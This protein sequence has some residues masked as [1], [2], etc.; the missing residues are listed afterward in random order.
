MKINAKDVK[1]PADVPK[2]MEKFYVQHYLEATQGSGRLMLFAGDQKMEHLNDDFVGLT[3]EGMRIPEDDSDP[4]H[5]FRIASKGT[6][7]VF[8]TQLGMIAR[9]GRDY[10][11]IPYLVKVNSK[12]DLVGTDQ[13]EPVSLALVDFEDILIMKEQSGLNVVGIGYTVFLGSELEAEML[14]EAG[15][16]VTW[17]HQNGMIAVLWM[18]PRGKAVKNDKDPHLIAGAAG[19][20]LCLGA[21]FAKVNYPKVDGD[22]KKRAQA[23]KEAVKA[24]GRTKIITSGGNARDVK[25]FLQETYDQIHISGCMGNATGRNI[26]QKA[27][28]EAVRM[29]DA[30][31]AITIGDKDVDFAYSVYKG[32][33]KFKV[34]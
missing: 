30:I 22:E 5:F 33:K 24:A 7:G 2:K 9:Y 20:A 18:Y 3:K 26:H 10:P 19:V 31:S 11:K 15:R 4:E 34:E 32:E 28:A 8:A 12:T 14:A 17:A 21:D 16:Y 13:A 23:F 6:I 25:V 27:L 29:C 1:V